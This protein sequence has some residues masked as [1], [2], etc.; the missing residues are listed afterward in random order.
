MSCN[1]NFSWHGQHVRVNV[2]NFSKP[3]FGYEFVPRRYGYEF[4]A[5]TFSSLEM[6]VVTLDLT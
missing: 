1:P 4:N 6:P 2:M 5:L 3:H